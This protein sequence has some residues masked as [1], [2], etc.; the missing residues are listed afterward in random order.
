MGDLGIWISGW[1]FPSGH[2]VQQILQKD[3]RVWNFREKTW[4]KKEKE[5]CLLSYQ[6]LRLYALLNVHTINR[7]ID[8]HWQSIHRIVC[9]C[10]SV[11]T[12]LQ[13]P[14]IQRKIQQASVHPGKLS[15]RVQRPQR[16][17]CRYDAHTQPARRTSPPLCCWWLLSAT[18]SSHISAN[19]SHIRWLWW[20]VV[21]HHVFLN[22]LLHNRRAYEFDIPIACLWVEHVLKIILDKTGS[23]HHTVH[24]TKITTQCK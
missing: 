11:N 6:P 16:W 24:C 7:Q 18:T 10:A 17:A 20:T 12:H 2:R 23:T 15:A 21:L 19:I 22:I 1:G 3:V 9:M 13:H 5:Q 14:G 8:R 4:K